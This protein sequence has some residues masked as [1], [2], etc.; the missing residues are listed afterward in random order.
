M[1][2]EDAVGDPAEALEAELDI[3]VFEAGLE[4]A[5]VGEIEAAEGDQRPEAIGCRERVEFG[6]SAFRPI[7]GDGGEGG[8]G[9]HVIGAAGKRQQFAG[10]QGLGARAKVVGEERRCVR[11]IGR[12]FQPGG[13]APV[14]FHF[15]EAALAVDWVGAPDP[16]VEIEGAIGAGGE[17]GRAEVFAATDERNLLC[18]V[19]GASAR[20]RVVFHAVIAPGRDE[21]AA[22]EFDDG[23][24][25]FAGRVDHAER[26]T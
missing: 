11:G 15:P 12:G 8:I 20:E 22:A 13:L 24:G 16:V 9:Q 26:T 7:A 4:P 18:C 5:V 10:G 6:R 25:A 17:A 1:L 3:L 14:D 19:I 2:L 21:Y 23:A